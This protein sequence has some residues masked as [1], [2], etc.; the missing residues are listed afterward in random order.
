LI[1]DGS[2][3]SNNL[4]V[5]IGMNHCAVDTA[6]TADRSHVKSLYFSLVSITCEEG[7]VFCIEI[8]EIHSNPQAI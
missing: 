3:Q 2:K 1:L 6:N 5:R 8:T 7:S 4:V